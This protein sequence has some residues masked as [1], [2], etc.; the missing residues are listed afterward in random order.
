MNI[1][2]LIDILGSDAQSR[3]RRT[4]RGRINK[5]SST[6]NESLSSTLNQSYWSIH[7]ESYG[8]ALNVSYSRGNHNSTSFGEVPFFSLEG[9]MLFYWIEG[10][11]RPFARKD[12]LTGQWNPC[13]H[14]F[15]KCAF[16]EYH[17]EYGCLLCKVGIEQLRIGRVLQAM[18]IF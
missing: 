7:N 18:K 5:L 14:S 6:L 4:F 9:M 3:G 12:R 11:H 15:G 13:E 10:H 1:W 17:S 2:L 16:G 8:S